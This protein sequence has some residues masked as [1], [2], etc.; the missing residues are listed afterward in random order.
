MRRSLWAKFLLL[1]LAVSAIAL[2]ATLVLRHLMVRDFRDY[3]DGQAEDRVYWITADAERTFELH[4]GWG[5]EWLAED[6]LWALMLGFEVRVLDAAGTLVFD[7]GRALERLTPKMRSRGLPALPADASTRGAF[8][9][10][11]LFLSGERIGTLEVRRIGPREDAGFVSRSNQFL[12]VSVLLL[13]GAAVALSTFA[14][15]RLTGRLALLARGAARIADGDLA[16][17]VPV[18]GQDELCSLAETF[19]RMAG[20]LQAL[21]DQ[22]KRLFTNLAHDLRTPLGAIRGE[23][24]GMMDGLIPATKEGLQSLHDEVGR[25]RRMLEGMEELASAQASALHL[26]RESVPLGALLR[27]AVERL[28]RGAPER[29]V[30]FQL[31]CP[32]DLRVDA[33]PDRLSQVVLNLLHNATK[34]V[35][36]DGR[37]SVRGSRQGDQVEI[38]VQDDGVGIAAADL[39][40]VFERFFRRSEGGL[41]VGLAIAKELVEAHG[42][43]IAIFSHL[44]QGTT[45]T[46]RLPA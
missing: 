16:A 7:T 45:V 22:R 15:R 19:N 43:R 3:L 29:Q 2:S 42:G 18:S 8:V 41:G 21:E 33:D 12:L 13:G 17:R 37:V 9:P 11:P 10:Y 23:L 35:G 34:A 38:L 44:G 46:V 26:R 6:A 20:A 27:Q 28:E 32:D 4:G 39:P 31:E 5:Q 25:L 24:E 14:S 30:A 1:L 36:P 40:F